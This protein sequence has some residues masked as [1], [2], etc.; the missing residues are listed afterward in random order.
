VFDATAGRA[1]LKDGVDTDDAIRWLQIVALG[2]MQAPS[3]VRDA[4]DLAAMLRLMLVPALIG[5]G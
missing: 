3:V 1:T 5:T 2:L 4:D